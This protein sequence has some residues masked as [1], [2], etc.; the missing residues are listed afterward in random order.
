MHL[1]LHFPSQTRIKHSGR[2]MQKMQFISSSCIDFCLCPSAALLHP[3]S[4]I[5]FRATRRRA[6]RDISRTH[7]FARALYFLIIQNAH[8]HT[9][10]GEGCAS[11]RESKRQRAFS[12]NQKPSVIAQARSANNDRVL[13][14]CTF[15][16]IKRC[17][18]S[19]F[20]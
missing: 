2:H 18:W 15:A 19:Q 17:S 8:T 10:V 5:N 9:G 4:G 14:L 6:T 12:N 13:V 16:R 7:Q 1:K 11:R 20:V 3:F